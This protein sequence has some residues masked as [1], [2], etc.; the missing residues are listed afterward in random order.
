MNVKINVINTNTII[1]G[2][3]IHTYR[4]WAYSAKKNET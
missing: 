4:A 1:E 3:Y 2:L